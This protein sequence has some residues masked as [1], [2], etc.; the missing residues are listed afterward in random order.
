MRDV[1]FSDHF[2]TMV[3]GASWW[4]S[5]RGSDG[6]DGDRMTPWR[7]RSG[8]KAIQ[9]F[10]DDAC[11][12]REMPIPLPIRIWFGRTNRNR[13]SFS[14]KKSEEQS[15]YCK[16]SSWGLLRGLLWRVFWWYLKHHIGHIART[17]LCIHWIYWP[18]L[19]QKY[20]GRQYLCKVS[21][22]LSCL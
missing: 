3:P 15:C 19:D 16:K 18:F 10:D 21:S 1:K 5:A 14:P 2:N 8:G 13:P 17:S 4:A 20:L 11:C 12:G 6:R 22:H 9:R 7:R